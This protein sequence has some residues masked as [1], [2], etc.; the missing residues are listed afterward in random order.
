[1]LGRTR[2]LDVVGIAAGEDRIGQACDLR[3]VVGVVGV[4]AEVLECRGDESQVALE[5][6][7]YAEQVRIAGIDGLVELLELRPGDHLVLDHRIDDEVGDLLVV[8]AGRDQ[9]D[10]PE[11]VLEHQVVVVRHRIAQVGIAH[12]VLL[13]M[14]VHT[15]A[16]HHLA[17]LR[18]CVVKLA[19]ST[20]L[21]I[22]SYLSSTEGSQLS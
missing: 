5:R 22:G 8:D 14:E 18:T 16:R 7:L 17:E 20:M 11:V 9:T 15:V 3:V 21:S 12:R 19:R 10:R 6:H 13:V 2:K 4:D 1:M